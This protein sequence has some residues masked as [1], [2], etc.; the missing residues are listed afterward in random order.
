[1]ITPAQCR[2][3]RALLDLSQK[4]LAELSLVSQ[5]SIQGFESG[6]RIIQP[7]SLSAILRIFEDRG[8][9]FLS[10]SGWTGVK[11]KTGN[12]GT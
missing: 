8:I 9:V 10:E 1:M 4:E 5:R 3:A 7:L 2:S 11:L 12:S 6:E